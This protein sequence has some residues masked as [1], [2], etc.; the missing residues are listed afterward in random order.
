M[1]DSM[2]SEA[3]LNANTAE[4]AVLNLLVSARGQAQIDSEG[5]AR[6]VMETRPSSL[7]VE[8]APYVKELEVHLS[9]RIPQNLFLAAAESLV[10]D[11]AVLLGKLESEY[12]S[13]YTRV[14]FS[15]LK[16]TSSCE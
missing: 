12:S 15:P 7:E 4:E 1:S 5:L 16:E 11:L 2:S 9:F 14:I 6:I 10:A 13:E 3:A 8:I